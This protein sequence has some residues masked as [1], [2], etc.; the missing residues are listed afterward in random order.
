MV[1]TLEKSTSSVQQIHNECDNSRPY[2]FIS[3]SSRDSSSVHSIVESIVDSGY[4][5]WIDLE[6]ENHIGDEWDRVVER[7][8][9]N[10]NCKCILWFVSSNSCKSVNVAHEL[11]FANSSFVFNSHNQSLSFS[12]S[13]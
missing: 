10:K 3:Y 5:V 12:S 11:E 8:I 2:C 9:L 4:N 6:L 1:Q 7:V 13:Y